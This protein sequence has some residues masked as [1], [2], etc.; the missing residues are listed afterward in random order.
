MVE[1]QLRTFAHL[2]ETLGQKQVRVIVDGNT[3]ED[4]FRVINEHFPSFTDHILS[5]KTLKPDLMIAI[6]GEQTVPHNPQSIFLQ[7]DDVITVLP[8]TGGG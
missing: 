1:V 5:E 2:R 6:N 7:D 4:F 8:P 3:L